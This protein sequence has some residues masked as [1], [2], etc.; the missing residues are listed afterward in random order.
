MKPKSTNLA[1]MTWENLWR[2]VH[3]GTED[4]EYLTNAAIQGFIKL[5][6]VNEKLEEVKACDV[7]LAQLTTELQRRKTFNLVDDSNQQGLKTA[8]KD[9]SKRVSR[10]ATIRAFL[11]TQQNSLSNSRRGAVPDV[12]DDEDSS[13]TTVLQPVIRAKKVSATVPGAGDDSSSSPTPVRAVASS[14]SSSSK[15]DKDRPPKVFFIVL[16]CRRRFVLRNPKKK[17]R[18]G[19]LHL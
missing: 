8:I 6:V 2:L 12:H 13:P 7:I 5:T 11:L 4:V 1:A 3:G 14:T 9:V 16:V 19:A 17:R 10:L 15:S 18:R